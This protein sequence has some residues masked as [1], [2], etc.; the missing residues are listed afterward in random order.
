MLST[1][2]CSACVSRSVRLNSHY[3][4]LVQTSALNVAGI[5]SRRKS[6]QTREPKNA[7][8]RAIKAAKKRGA[9]A[10]ASIS[11]PPAPRSPPPVSQPHLEV[12]SDNDATQFPSSQRDLSST[13]PARLDLPDGPAEE[14]NGSITIK[15]RASYLY[16]LGKG[17]VGFYKT[18]FWNVWSNYKEYRTLRARFAGTDMHDLVKHESTP[19]ITRRE[20]QLCL[21]TQHDLK[22]LAP[23]A[24][25][26]LVCGEFTPLV[27]IALGTAV[28]PFTCRIPK[29][30]TKD[31][32]STLSRIEN[33]ERLSQ[34]QG[35]VNMTPA[36]ANVHGLDPFGLVIREIPVLSP[37]LWRYWV[38]PKLKKHMDNI[39]CD[40]LL[41][42]KEG[43]IGRLEEE[44]LADF[45]I[46]IRKVDTI[47][48]LIDH[49]VV[50]AQ[51]CFTK[52]ELKRTQKTL[53]PFI[54]QIQRQMSG[55][56]KEM[57]YQPE[58][59]FISAAEHTERSEEGGV[60]YIP[61][62]NLVKDS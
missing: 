60:A 34:Q 21:R 20:F 29:Q 44:E 32:R 56:E 41:I 57:A 59:V 55:Q 14:E 12:S 53:Q 26:F 18:G 61:P 30:I 45:C 46:K 17:Y 43:G 3:R 38:E 23:F 33:V 24:L 28:V 11:T 5:A 27:I 15:S 35:G 1:F 62:T 52:S 8:S 39:I 16:R 6:T 42:A 50:G 47:Q 10:Y 36:L 25:V 49:H 37:L 58:S 13:R 19:G 48:R 31:L 7:T 40:A 54:D 51:S 4:A 2:S 9:G 22:K